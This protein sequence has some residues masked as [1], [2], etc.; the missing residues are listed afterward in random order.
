MNA[1]YLVPL[2]CT[3]T[4]GLMAFL[5]NISVSG[6]TIEESILSIVLT[7]DDQVASGK[8]AFAAKKAIKT[9]TEAIRTII[10][11]SVFF[12]ILPLYPLIPLLLLAHKM[13]L[14]VRLIRLQIPAPQFLMKLHQWFELRSL[15]YVKLASKPYYHR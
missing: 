6:A 13:L 5:L 11:I 4:A 9:L 7:L 2:I 14:L 1:P 8:I 10:A 3:W 12:I 15:D